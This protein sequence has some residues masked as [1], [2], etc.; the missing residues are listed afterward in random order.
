MITAQPLRNQFTTP[1]RFGTYAS[2]GR[3]Q[4][5]IAPSLN[6]MVGSLSVPKLVEGSVLETTQ[7]GD[8]ELE[9]SV[10]DMEESDEAEHRLAALEEGMARMERKLDRILA[11]LEE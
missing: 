1:T 11:I 8:E 5:V 9:E 7:S 3:G 10:L 4:L 6:S 2:N